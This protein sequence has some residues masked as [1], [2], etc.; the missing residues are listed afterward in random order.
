MFIWVLTEN[1]N[2]V[3]THQKELLGLLTLI[4]ILYKLVILP[5]LISPL[6]KVP[7]PYI[8]RISPL[9]RI[10]YQA[11]FQWVRKVHE[12][13][14][15]YG[16]IV[17]IA[18]NEVN[19][20]GSTYVCD[21]YTK[22]MPKLSYYGNFKLYG[23][24]NLFST[25]DNRKHLE[26]KKVL[27]TGYSKSSLA[28]N[29]LTR[30]ILSS[31]VSRL[32]G[33]VEKTSVLAQSPDYL[34]ARLEANIHGKGHQLKTSKWL[35]EKPKNMG[36]DVYSLFGAMSMDAVTAFELGAKNGTNMLENP[37][38]RTAL[39]QY[40]EQAESVFWMS[41]L[42]QLPFSFSL[43]P[44]AIELWLVNLFDKASV[45]FMGNST[46][47]NLFRN[48]ITGSKAHSLVSDN[49][50]AGHE[51]TAFALTYV[52]YELSRPVHRARQEALR[53]ELR[54]AFGRPEKDSDV[55]VDMRTIDSLPYLDAILQEN[56]RVHTSGPGF[57]PRELPETY[58]IDTEEG[59]D[60]DNEKPGNRKITLP[61]GTIVSCQQH[62][63]H[64]IPEIFPQP[65]HWLPERWLQNSGEPDAHHKRRVAK[66]NKHIML[67]GKGV[68]MC[69]GMNF[70]LAEIKCA[71]A[72]LYWRYESRIC[73]DWCDVVNYGTE[74][75]NGAP[76]RLVLGKLKAT[77]DEAMMS[78]IDSISTRPI[79]DE[80]WL[81]WGDAL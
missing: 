35:T 44:E 12:L 14:S 76:L 31:Q 8:H 29:S 13:H 54:A 2:L 75:K 41:V 27:Q 23:H 66:M 48:G 56:F 64:R 15:K 9:P 30:E 72:N 61:K 18:P 52:C 81:E 16:P 59:C 67:F 69:L 77:T 55:I 63:L 37:E 62:L 50:I 26:S 5:L 80:C 25:L 45:D 24:D 20:N 57:L 70:A 36:I 53:A 58:T 10:W 65:D 74:E 73:S 78:M 68:R 4:A 38:E 60:G 39:V 34:N 17:I 47:A 21:F 71:L 1:W 22:N 19:F 40:R 3:E 49:I 79:Y 11:N 51:T 28:C 32:L 7:G 6:R 43:A 46:M 33:Q 42:P